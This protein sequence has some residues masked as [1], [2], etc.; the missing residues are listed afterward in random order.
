MNYNEHQTYMAPPAMRPL[1]MYSVKNQL[2]NQLSLTADSLVNL[3][4]VSNDHALRIDELRNDLENMRALLM[5]ISE[6]HPDVIKQHFA[7]KDIERANK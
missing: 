5:W 1:D 4:Q 3:G 6:V 7:L 2:A